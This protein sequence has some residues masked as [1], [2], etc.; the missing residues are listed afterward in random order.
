MEFTSTSEQQ[1]YDFAKKFAATL[2]G[3]EI[4]G[5]VGDLGAGKTVF[6]KGLAAGLGVKKTITSPTFVLMKVYEIKNQK[7][8]TYPMPRYGIKNLI[9]I[10]AYR[11]KS[12]QDLI[13]IGADEF[14]NR[15]DTVT[16]IEWVDKIKSIFIKEIISIYIIHKE[17]LRIFKIKNGNC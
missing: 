5:L 10:D 14:F 2:K 6:T 3:G 15:P 9:H 13:A 16:V 4:I 8:K 17:N 1:T 11:V 12:A 7:S